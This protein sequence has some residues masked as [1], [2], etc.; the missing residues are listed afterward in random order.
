MNAISYMTP[1]SQTE[2]NDC[3]RACV[4][5]ILAIPITDLPIPPR[6]LTDENWPEYVDSLKNIVRNLGFEL[7]TVDY[8]NDYDRPRGFSIASYPS[9]N[10]P[11]SDVLHA[12]VALNGVVYWDPS[13]T[14]RRRN[15]QYEGAPKDWIIFQALY[16]DILLQSHRQHKKEPD[17]EKVSREKLIST[18][19]SVRGM[20]IHYRVSGA[21]DR[22]LVDQTLHELDA[23]EAIIVET[24]LGDEEVNI[25]SI[26]EVEV[27]D[28]KT[29]VSNLVSKSRSAERS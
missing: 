9:P 6:I 29:V 22:T 4:A 25:H 5:S 12:V 23:V 26:A 21:S 18:L 20:L 13:P 1:V 3:F 10:N 19:D 16:P 8:E 7:F 14:Y 17:M 2:G 27:N 11:D 28:T 15:V 24:V